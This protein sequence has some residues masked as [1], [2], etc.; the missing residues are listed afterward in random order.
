MDITFYV[1]MYD[2]SRKDN[3]AY[4]CVAVRSRHTQDLSPNLDL[5]DWSD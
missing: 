1:H 3:L 2:K 5:S 4:V